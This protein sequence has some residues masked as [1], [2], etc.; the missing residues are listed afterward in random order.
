MSMPAWVWSQGQTDYKRKVTISLTVFPVVSTGLIEER[1]EAD[2]VV[3]ENEANGKA[4]TGT[5][6]NDLFFFLVQMP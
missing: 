6:K 4:P 5:E 3:E 1:E 2:E